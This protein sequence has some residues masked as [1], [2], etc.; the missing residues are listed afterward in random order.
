MAVEK[1]VEEH[2][3]M[4]PKAIVVS[5]PVQLNFLVMKDGREGVDLQTYHFRLL[6]YSQSDEL[7]SEG[8]NCGG[9]FGSGIDE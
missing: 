4:L 2:Q 9:K 3:Y 6:Y 1:T 5:L 8:F 7:C